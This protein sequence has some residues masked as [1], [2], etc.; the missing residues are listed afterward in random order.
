MYFNDIIGQEKLK[1]QL[2]QNICSNR[3]SHAQLFAESEGSGALGMALAY[4]RYINCKNPTQNDSCGTCPPCLKFNKIAHPDLHIFYPTAPSTPGTKN[5]SSKTYI[6]QFRE[7][8]LETHYLSLSKWYNHIGIEKKHAIINKD[9]CNEIIHLANLKTYESKYKIFIVWMAEKLYHSAA[10]KLLKI[11]EEP[12]EN[13][14]FI[15]ISHNPSQIPE[16]I[17]S[18]LQMISFPPLPSSEIKKA[19]I[20]KHN[21]SE[22]IASQIS[23]QASGNFTEALSQIHLAQPENSFYLFRNWMRA[24]YKPSPSEIFSYTDEIASYGREEQKAFLQYGLKTINECLLINYNANKPL[25]LFEEESD[26]LLKF[27]K[28][29]NH[30][31][32]VSVT[33]CFN[34][35][36]KYIG[37]NA[38]SKIVIADLSYRMHKLLRYGSN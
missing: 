30:N 9:D 31:N 38:N 1:K 26:F 22:E 32:I 17:L 3:I 19:L 12:P 4:S 29:V 33:N 10:P 11:L 21:C 35:T 5:V 28:L 13:T 20:E 7:A 18:R 23:F 14:I 36:I 6:N 25:K 2:I 8:L 27:S 15:F 37:R 24:C 34:D 16:T